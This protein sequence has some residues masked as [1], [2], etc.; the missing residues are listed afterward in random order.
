MTL[1]DNTPALPPLS[2]RRTLS[3]EQRMNEFH[4]KRL[5][6]PAQ[7]PLDRRRADTDQAGRADTDEAGTEDEAALKQAR[8]DA[9]ECVV[10]AFAAV[11][12]NLA[13]AEKARSQRE[14]S[15]AAVEKMR[16]DLEKELE[17]ARSA[18]EEAE[19]DL[20]EARAR[21]QELLSEA[22]AR[23]DALLE[24]ARSQCRTEV[25]MARRCLIDTLA[26]LRD[27]VDQ[28]TVTI[29]AFVGSTSVRKQQPEDTVDIRDDAGGA[30]LTRL[31]TSPIAAD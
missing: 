16:L 31:V 12:R 8:A 2:Q 22:R 3:P 18:R 29:D 9:V 13:L 25:E 17:S 4:A 26:P 15:R 14:T 6:G 7:H 19:G 10:K 27:V 11:D 5:T 23:S 24:A 30:T 1:T 21:S 28:T 20:A